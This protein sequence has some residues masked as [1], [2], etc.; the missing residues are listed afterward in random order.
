VASTVINTK[1]D[2]YVLDLL[3]VTEE[4]LIKLYE[5]LEAQGL[6]ETKKQMKEEGLFIG[7]TNEAK[8]PQYNTR[9]ALSSKNVDRPY[10]DEDD[11]NDEGLEDFRGYR[12][13]IK[14]AS[15]QIV[16][17]KTKK[18]QVKNKKK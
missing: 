2:E 15:K 8:L 4:K 13:Q 17:A 1:S 16:D 9:I 7:N 11:S 5:D 12:D 3:S 14:Q 6:N 18:H 10:E